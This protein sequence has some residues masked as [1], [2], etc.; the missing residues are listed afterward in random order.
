MAVLCTV[1]RSANSLEW[2]TRKTLATAVS[3]SE[4]TGAS[5]GFTPLLS[6]QLFGTSDSLT[7]FSLT[8]EK[9]RHDSFASV[10]PG[11]LAAPPAKACQRICCT[12]SPVAQRHCG[13][14][15][16]RYAA[17]ANR[18]LS[19]LR[20]IERTS[21]C[22]YGETEKTVA[23]LSAVQR[24]SVCC[25]ATSQLLAVRCHRARV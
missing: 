24:L 3:L 7:T 23:A 8:N 11:I 15:F 21:A 20:I 16:Q 9:H 19:A 18:G 6:G 10:A 17:A 2:A 22:P 1:L 12:Q 25:G 5:R 13:S 4:P 14:G